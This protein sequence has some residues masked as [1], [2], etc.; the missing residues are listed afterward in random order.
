MDPSRT[1]MLQLLLRTPLLSVHSDA[2]FWAT[3]VWAASARAH[4]LKVS[5]RA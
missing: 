2:Q 3:W 1:S 4:I 5:A